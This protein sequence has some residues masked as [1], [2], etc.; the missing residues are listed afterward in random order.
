MGRVK[1]ALP[2]AF[3]FST[4]IPLR[5]SDITRRASGQ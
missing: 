3:I 2:D 4:E 1:L 5:V